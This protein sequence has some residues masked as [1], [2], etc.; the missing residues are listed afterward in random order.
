MGKEKPETLDDTKL[1][2]AEKRRWNYLNGI[3][4]NIIVFFIINLFP[5][6]M[7]LTHGVVTGKWINALWAMDLSIIVKVLGNILLISYSPKWF[8]AMIEFFITSAALISISVFFVVFPLDFSI[9][10]GPW[11]NTVI[12][13]LL[14]AGI[15]GASIGTIVWLG[16]FLRSVSGFEK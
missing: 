4:S 16:R 6:W 14:I 9:L 11:L 5:L 1:R 8:R 3:I 15:V 10:T 2:K 7:P 13:C 12:R